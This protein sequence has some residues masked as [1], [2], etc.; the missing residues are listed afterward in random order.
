[1]P[2]TPKAMPGDNGRLG[3]FLTGDDAMGF[4]N[5]LETVAYSII[6][7]A[8]PKDNSVQWLQHRA[9]EIRAAIGFRED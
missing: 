5:D 7:E 8:V 1:M 3:V 2:F 9:A 4:A 6:K